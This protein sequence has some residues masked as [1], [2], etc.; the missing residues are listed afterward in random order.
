[1]FFREF[2]IFLAAYGK[3]L[4]KV[5]CKSCAVESSIE[6][7]TILIFLPFLRE[8]AFIYESGRV[9]MNNHPIQASLN[10]PSFSRRGVQNRFSLSS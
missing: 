1:L 4:L 5:N 2:G 6:V 9:F 10:F 7:N 8:G 3:G